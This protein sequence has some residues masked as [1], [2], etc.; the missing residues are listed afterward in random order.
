MNRA[1]EIVRNDNLI[2]GRDAERR[3]FDSASLS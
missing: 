3:Q 2:F 1:D